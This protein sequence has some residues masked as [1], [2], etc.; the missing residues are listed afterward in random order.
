MDLTPH[1]LLHNA[2]TEE[3]KEVAGDGGMSVIGSQLAGPHRTDQSQRLV[4]SMLAQSSQS[5]QS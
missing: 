1:V 3:M 2:N 5:S 4:S